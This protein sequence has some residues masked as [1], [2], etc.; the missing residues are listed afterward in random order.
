MARGGL[1]G[2]AAAG[3]VAALLG[4]TGVLAVFE[5]TATTGALGGLD[6]EEIVTQARGRELD[7][8]LATYDDDPANPGSGVC[9]P[10]LQ[11]LDTGIFSET[12][13]DDPL[14]PLGDVIISDTLGLC[15]RNT[16]SQSIA[17][18]S[19]G[20]SV[21]AREQF[22]NG[23]TGDEALTD[24]DGAGCGTRGEA[25]NSIY[26]GIQQQTCGGELEYPPLNYVLATLTND[27]GTPLLGSANEALEPGETIC[28]TIVAR[29][30]PLSI[31]DVVAEQ[32]DI[33]RWR[34]R[35]RG[36]AGA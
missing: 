34:F 33:V 8:T 13:R 7:L 26:W 12:T 17:R 14:R 9:G 30:D 18:G 15:V 3:A 31:D 10:F 16:G 22:E 29:Y 32:S 21:F 6:R 1:I 11:D 5:D 19:L 4:A 2:A 20:I 35:I 28:F 24:P 25:A 36:S 23:C 27:D